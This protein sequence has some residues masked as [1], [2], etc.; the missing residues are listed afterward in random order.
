MSSLED[1]KAEGHLSTK[2][3]NHS[4][5][6][7][8]DEHNGTVNPRKPKAKK[9]STHRSYL[10][11]QAGGIPVTEGHRLTGGSRPRLD[12]QERTGA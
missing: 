7:I 5:R 11:E 8:I 1:E 2:E 12:L 3:H 9:G 10:A 6:H 4:P